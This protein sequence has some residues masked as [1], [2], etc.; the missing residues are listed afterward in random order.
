MVEERRRQYKL[1]EDARANV[2][3]DRIN[4]AIFPHPNNSPI[5]TPFRFFESTSNDLE[6]SSDE[7]FSDDD[8]LPPANLSPIEKVESLYQSDCNNKRRK[9]KG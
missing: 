8:E 3:Q 1:C 2:L 6:E 5:H 7:V 9:R 4:K